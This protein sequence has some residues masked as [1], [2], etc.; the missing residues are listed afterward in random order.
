[1]YFKNCAVG[2]VPLVNP[3]PQWCVLQCT[4][5]GDVPHPRELPS[6]HRSG[7]RIVEV[8]LITADYRYNSE[9]GKKMMTNQES[10]KEFLDMVA[11]I[12][13]DKANDKLTGLLG[14]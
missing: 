5:R 12:F 13:P 14:D 6:D 8:P 4:H 7:A 9:A 3:G 10:N 1:M 2:Q 11:K